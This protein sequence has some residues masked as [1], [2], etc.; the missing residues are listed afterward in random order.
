MN[1]ETNYI[2][3][4]ND[5][6]KIYKLGSVEV[7]ALNGVSFS[8]KKGEFV[9]IMGASGSG[10]STLMHI[11]GCLDRPTHGRIFMDEVD[12]SLMQRDELAEIRN[13]K[14][15]FV[16]Q[17]FNLLSRVNALANVELPLLYNGT[18]KEERHK[19]AFAALERVG[20]GDR[21]KH[22]PSEMSGGQQQRVAIARALI[23]NPPL[24]MADEP[25]GNLDSKSGAEI[26]EILKDLNRNGHTIVVVTHDRTIAENAQRI[27]I[28]KDGKISE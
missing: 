26:I 18:A 17:M 16:F 28:L 24:I 6:V 2:I 4:A 3:Q 19:R 12:T 15:G 22:H 23:T 7:Y 9:S 13:K 1:K 27:I 20:L 14:I 25:T 8:V 21:I 11:I 5:L 10:K